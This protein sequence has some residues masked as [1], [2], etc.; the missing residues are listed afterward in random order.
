MAVAATGCK[1]SG[2]RTAMARRTASTTTDW[3]PEGEL[4]LTLVPTESSPWNALEGRKAR[5]D[6]FLRACS[7][8][9]LDVIKF[10]CPEGTLHEVPEFVKQAKE[11]L[12]L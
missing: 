11:V 5:E 4:L 10:T 3:G 12:E 7:L 9:E 2:S 1:E 6:D 8:V